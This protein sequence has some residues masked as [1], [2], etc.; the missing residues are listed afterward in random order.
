M[1]TEEIHH[2]NRNNEDIEIVQDFAYLDSVINSNGNCSQE[3]KR[4]LRLRRAEMKEL[5]KIKSK[6]VSL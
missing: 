5:E 4:I 2:F 6:G 3:I 1:T